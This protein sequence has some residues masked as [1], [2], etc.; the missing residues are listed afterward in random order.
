[1][2]AGSPVPALSGH[3]HWTSDQILCL[4]RRGYRVEGAFLPKCVRVPRGDGGRAQD[5]PLAVQLGRRPSFPANSTVW[6]GAQLELPP[7]DTPKQPPSGAM[8][9][10]GA[11]EA[12]A[13]P[14]LWLG[15]ALRFKA[16]FLL[17]ATN[18][19]DR[20]RA[21][22][23]LKLYG[24]LEQCRDLGTCPTRFECRACGVSYI[25]AGPLAQRRCKMGADCNYYSSGTTTATSPD[26]ITAEVL[27]SP[28]SY[29]TISALSPFHQ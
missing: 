9:G 15:A 1:M 23:A 17:C 24:S 6:F 11:T 12:L 14:P 19:Q 26:E 7:T 27:C 8:G 22:A 28:S 21:Q 2:V 5:L 3:K 29:Y 13:L 4:L 16:A 18:I 10:D 20:R 25:E